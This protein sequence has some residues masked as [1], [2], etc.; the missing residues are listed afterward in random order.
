MSHVYIYIYM[1][2]YILFFTN[3]S[4]CYGPFSLKFAVIIL[5]I[6]ILQGFTVRSLDLFTQY[7][8]H[9]LLELVDLDL[10]SSNEELCGHYHVMPRFARQ[11]SGSV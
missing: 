2:K 1:C 4:Y 9:E 3:T 5:C 10:I 11:L 6:C 8:Y 7:L